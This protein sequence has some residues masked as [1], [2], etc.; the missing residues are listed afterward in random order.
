MLSTRDS[1]HHVVQWR[2]VPHSHWPDPAP[3]RRRRRILFTGI[4]QF[5]GARPRSEGSESTGRRARSCGRSSARRRRRRRNPFL[6]VQQQGAAEDAVP[7]RLDPAQAPGHARDRLGRRVHPSTAE[8]STAPEAAPSPAPHTSASSS[9]PERLRLRRSAL[10][11]CGKHRLRRLGRGQADATAVALRR[12]ADYGD[13][14]SGDLHML[15]RP[16]YR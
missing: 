8:P 12:A 13:A 7:Q 3:C 14:T 6:E 10:A 2:R 11:L 9:R 1:C 4:T 15:R 5:P 16:A